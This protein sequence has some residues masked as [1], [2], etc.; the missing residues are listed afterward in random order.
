VTHYESLEISPSATRDEIRKAYRAQA[1]RFHPDA[2]GEGSA[3]RMS[4]IN[5]AW[6]VLSDPGRRASYD[7]SL[8]AALVTVGRPTSSAKTSVYTPSVTPRV[9]EAERARFPW[10]FMLLMAV[11]GIGFVLVNA[12]LTNPTTPGAPDNLLQVGSC[13]IFSD[14]N[15]AVET[16]CDSTH[17]GAVVALVAFDATCPPGT[18]EHR[19]RQ[20]MG[21]ACVQLSV[22]G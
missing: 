15:E 2:P 13:V 14:T 10:R 3:R 1:R 12:A 11:L 20:G 17:V 16:S 6:H 22:N 9:Y 19:D 21:L 4:A 18:E 8:R 7:E 5:D